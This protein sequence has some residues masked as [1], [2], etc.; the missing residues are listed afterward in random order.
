[1]SKL[2][3]WE[4]VTGSSMAY[5]CT[6]LSLVLREA[7]PYGETRLKSQWIPKVVFSLSQ[8]HPA[9]TYELMRSVA[10]YLYVLT[11]I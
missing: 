2:V 9:A 3:P 6:F 11:W 8:I 4:K 10:L 1:M 5:D 7:K